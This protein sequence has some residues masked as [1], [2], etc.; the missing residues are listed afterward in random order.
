MGTTT[1]PGSCHC[2]AVKYEVEVDLAEPASRCNCSI[3]TRL[4]ATTQIVKPA[5]LR[6]L[7]GEESLTRYEWGGRTG[8]RYFCKVCGITCLLRGHLDV[9]G[10]DYV[11]LS[12]NTLEDVDPSTLEVVHWDG[13][14]DNWMAGSRDTPWPIFS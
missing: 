4:G 1:H 8:Q 9:L 5:A 3:C 12:L 7:Q 6:L 10:G 14:H 2:G 11:S 13:R